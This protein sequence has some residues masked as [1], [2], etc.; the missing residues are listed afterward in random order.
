MTIIAVGHTPE[1]FD[2]LRN[3]LRT[4]ICPIVFVFNGE[5]RD[6]SINVENSLYGRDVA[7]YAEGIKHSDSDRLIFINDDTQYISDQW[8]KLASQFVNG[9]QDYDIA[10]TPNLSSWVDHSLLTGESLRHAQRQGSTNKFIRTSTFMC[11]REY[12]NTLW[13][14]CNG[15]AQRFEKSTLLSYKRCRLLNPTWTYDSNTQPYV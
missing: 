9:H 3:M 15:D 8:W 5:Y 14:G 12:F 6:D 13:K 2:N 11:T 4:D 1:K 10:G 7:M